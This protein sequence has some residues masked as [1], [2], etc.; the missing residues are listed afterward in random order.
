VATFKSILSIVRV[1]TTGKGAGAMKEAFLAA[2]VCVMIFSAIAGNTE[3][4]TTS[5]G[6]GLIAAIDAS[7]PPH[8]FVRDVPSSFD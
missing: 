1:L 5:S 2:A 8:S 6:A 7:D 4:L 3:L